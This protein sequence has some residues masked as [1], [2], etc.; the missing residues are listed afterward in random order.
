MK[1]KSG[2]YDF[3]ALGVKFW[4]YVLTLPQRIMGNIVT[5]ALWLMLE[6]SFIYVFFNITKLRLNYMVFLEFRNTIY[7]LKFIIVGVGL[8]DTPPT[9]QL[10]LA[11][12]CCGVYVCLVNTIISTILE[13]ISAKY[14]VKIL[15]SIHEFVNGAYLW[16]YHWVLA[17][18]LLVIVN[19]G[20]HGI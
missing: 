17:M 18:Y 15:R 9:G 3:M 5:D 19:Y 20:Y 6:I 7:Y 8:I 16:F 4:T 1:N 10:E 12:S 13:D 11:R 2:S 14:Y